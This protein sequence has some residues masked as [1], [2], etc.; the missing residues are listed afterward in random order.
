MSEGD[1]NVKVVNN[2]V[3]IS[4]SLAEVFTIAELEAEIVRGGNRVTYPLIGA[5]QELDTEG[6]GS[7][8]IDEAH[9]VHNTLDR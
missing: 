5:L 8:G 6:P 1:G 4:T 2:I 3:T 7:G 9:K